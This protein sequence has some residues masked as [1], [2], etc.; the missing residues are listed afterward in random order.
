MVQ[1]SRAKKILTKLF[2]RSFMYTANKLLPWNGQLKSNRRSRF[3][4]PAYKHPTYLEG[5]GGRGNNSNNKLSPRKPTE[6]TVRGKM[7][8]V[9]VLLGNH[10]FSRIYVLVLFIDTSL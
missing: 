5:W 2:A 8:L 9:P 1:H 4:V 3:R 10:F 6:I 7:L